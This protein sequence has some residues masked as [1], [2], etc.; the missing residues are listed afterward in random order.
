M[1]R[2]G[3]HIPPDVAA[4]LRAQ[5]ADDARALEHL[6]R[7]AG[8]TFPDAPAPEARR[9]AALWRALDAATTPA[10]APDLTLPDA[11]A[12]PEALASEWNA[13]APLRPTDTP[14]PDPDRIRALWADLDAAA[15]PPADNSSSRPRSADRAPAARAAS[16][17]RR[18]R[19]LGAA[20]LVVAVLA[21]GLALWLQQT[22]SVEAPHAR[23]LA[24]ADGSQVDLDEG[25]VLRYSRAYGL[26]TR[27]V[28]LSGAAFFDVER[29]AAPF[30]VETPNAR[31]QVRGT[32]FQVRT[33]TTAD[34]P[35]TT[36]T[37]AE[38]VVEVR[39]KGD[40]DGIVVLRANQGNVVTGDAAP[41]PAAVAVVADSLA[42]RFR[43]AFYD[44][45]L[46]TIA[47]AIADRF[48]VTIDVPASLRARR[49]TF[50]KQRADDVAALLDDL[51]ATTGL[52]YRTVAPNHYALVEP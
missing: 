52:Q 29:D 19:T 31:I 24:L 36:V 38:G 46:G 51:S 32:A 41:T 21:A 23:R 3:S 43:F 49:H 16:T 6:W 27:R 22:T 35:R 37:V 5:P 25:A 10:D 39:A 15:T 9:I 26:R 47:D 42:W 48:G 7:A 34:G 17:R 44:A 30:I 33:W 1:P 50:V 2:P 40:P 45:T 20:A 18:V 8:Q 13:A 11:E 14:A 12:L 28:H 4:W